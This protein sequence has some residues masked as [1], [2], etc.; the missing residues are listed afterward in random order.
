VSVDII[1]RMMELSSVSNNF[2]LETE[3]S[4]IKWREF[5][6]L[7]E[8]FFREFGFETFRNYR[9][10]SPRLEIDLL[11]V[12]NERGFAADCKHWRRTVGYSVMTAIASKQA[13]RCRKAVRDY[14]N[15]PAKSLI[16][17]VLTLHDEMLQIVD[18]G[19]A[20]VPIRKLRDFLLNWENFKEDL[21]AISR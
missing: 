11:A 2:D 17:I 4:K 12:K 18:G 10:K 21:L 6:G 1:Q 9:L 13:E 14:T 19:V 8:S 7:A 16:P 20:V 5:E 15:C 3:S